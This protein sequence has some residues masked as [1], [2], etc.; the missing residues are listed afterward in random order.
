MQSGSTEYC[1]TFIFFYYRDL[2]II[3]WNTITYRW[4]VI[5][6]L[7]FRHMYIRSKRKFRTYFCVRMLKTKQFIYS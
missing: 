3:F 7:S 2:F 5:L 1:S 4:L 6:D